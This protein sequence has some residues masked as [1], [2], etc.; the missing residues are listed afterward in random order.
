MISVTA[1]DYHLIQEKEFFTLFRWVIH[2]RNKRW[3]NATSHSYMS[4]HVWTEIYVGNPHG[5]DA[6]DDNDDDN[7]D[8]DDNENG[9]GGGSQTNDGWCKR[10]CGQP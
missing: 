8:D 10:R 3:S 7:D 9:G 4:A 6:D 1:D 5:D 2:E